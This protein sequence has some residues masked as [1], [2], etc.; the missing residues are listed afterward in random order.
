MEKRLSNIDKNLWSEVR[1]LYK[2]YNE[3][4]AT[5]SGTV[6][7]RK[8]L[9]ALTPKEREVAK[10]AAFRLSNQEITDKLHMSLPTV[11]Q[12]IRTISEKSGMSRS[13]FAAFL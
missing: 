1:N 2:I 9:T 12:E 7:G 10:L 6:R 3:G 8:V 11:K 4:W 5:L 13:D